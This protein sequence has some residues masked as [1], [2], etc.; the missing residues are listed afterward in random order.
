MHA[1]GHIIRTPNRRGGVMVMT[2]LL[3][4]LLTTLALAMAQL[5][6]RELVH[7]DSQAAGYDAMLAAE[8]GMDIL[9]IAIQNMEPASP[10][11]TTLLAGVGDQLA[12]QS[13]L[14]SAP[15]VDAESG[16]L[17]IPSLSL[18][19]SSFTAE[20]IPSAGGS[21]FELRVTGT[22]DDATR[23]VSKQFASSAVQMPIFQSRDRHSRP[24]EHRRGLHHVRCAGPGPA[25]TQSR[26][27]S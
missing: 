20:L 26:V 7:V 14:S 27:H 9:S 6:V 5:G 19:Q 17:I 25:G 10:S 15:Y 16:S 21:T 23:T 1:S 18:G 8:S 22:H 11:N 24:P 13:T 4:L 3:V 12:E 2:L